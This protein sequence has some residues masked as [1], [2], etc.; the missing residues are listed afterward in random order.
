M[1]QV[2]G[3]TVN[4][5]KDIVAALQRYEASLNQTNISWLFTD[6]LTKGEASRRALQSIFDSLMNDL[7][8]EIGVQV[9]AIE[10]IAATLDANYAKIDSQTTFRKS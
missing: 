1:A 2:T 10:K 6:N 8:K 5:C 3:I 7:R 4:A 9:D